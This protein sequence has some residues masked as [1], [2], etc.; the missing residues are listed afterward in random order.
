VGKADR[1][2]AVLLLGFSAA[3][4]AGALKYY[5][6]WGDS[7]PGPAFM[8]FWI[9][10]VMSA[11]ALL[12]LL[13]KSTNTGDDWMPSREGARRVL[14]VLGVTVAFVVLMQVVGMIVGGALFL[15]VLMRYL[16]RQ[17]WWLTIVVSFSAA[18]FNW[19]VFAHW[20][21]VPIPQG[22]FWTF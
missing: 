4:S 12:L 2:T 11:L 8:P 17:P 1:I 18:A 14:V 15:A 16:E 19:L 21:H 9:G 7:G 3:F 6:W 13:R 10:L 20:L 22:L 5:A